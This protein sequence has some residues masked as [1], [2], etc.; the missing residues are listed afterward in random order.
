MEDPRCDGHAADAKARQLAG[1]RQRH[2]GESRL[3][4][5]VGRLP[6]LSF[7]S[8]HR[9][10]VD[11]Q[12]ALAVGVRCVV[13]H[14]GGG[15]LVA[16]ECAD[17][18]DVHDLG[19]EVS[20]HRPALA[21]DAP[22]TDHA[23]AVDEQVDPAHALFGDVH[24]RIDLGLGGDVATDERGPFPE[25]GGRGLSWPLLHVENGDSAPMGDDVASHPLPESGGSARDDRTRVCKLHTI[26]TAIATASPPPMQS[27]A[28]PRFKPLRRRA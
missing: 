12:S 15:R 5:G 28:M 19:E 10:D 18:V 23:R 7:E 22:G 27:E 14:E 11:Q 8:G 9:S 4:G 1:D 17:Q 25:C 2:A 26:S 3:G 24:A 16:Q 20:G 13:L 6:D 21:Q